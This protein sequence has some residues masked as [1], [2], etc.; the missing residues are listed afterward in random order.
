MGIYISKTDFTGKYAVAKNIFDSLDDYIDKYEET[1]LIQL[2]GWELYKLFKADL[3]YVAP[4]PATA[5]YLALWDKFTEDDGGD[6]I[7]SNGMKE[8]LLGFIFF[9]F[10]RDL[11][12]KAT[13]GGIS[14]NEVEVSEQADI[15]GNSLN[16]KYNEA[17]GTYQAIQWYIADNSE[18]YPEY[19]G[20]KKTIT[21]WSL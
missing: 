4:P 9:E 5:I 16:S 8:M 10:M 14:V 20:Q 7:T 18:D 13:A 11:P 3:Q 2:L 21:H 6:I 1:Y 17:V 19:N 15:S 12:Y